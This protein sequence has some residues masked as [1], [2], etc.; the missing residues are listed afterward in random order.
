MVAKHG[1][2]VVLLVLLRSH[3]M[4][5]HASNVSGASDTHLGPEPQYEYQ[6]A[7]NSR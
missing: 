1:R 5:A 3:T 6:A 7:L 4:I 2:S